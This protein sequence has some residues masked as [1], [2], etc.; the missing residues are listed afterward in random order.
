MYFNSK[1]DMKLN[2]AILMNHHAIGFDITGRTNPYSI[3]SGTKM[4]S[5]PAKK[6][7]KQQQCCNNFGAKNNPQKIMSVH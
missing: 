3:Q 6:K 4:L 2:H 5:V 7:K 1:T